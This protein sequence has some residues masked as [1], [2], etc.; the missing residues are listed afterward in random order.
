MKKIINMSLIMAL[1][2]IITISI[3]ACGDDDDTKDMTPP[4]ISAEG[5]TANPINC[6]EYHPGDVIPFHYVMTDNQELGAY[7]IEIHNNFDHH[8]HSTEADDHDH[9]HGT[10][11]CEED[12]DHEHE[13][14]EGKA[15]VYNQD[16]TIPAG[17]RSYDA[18]QD[19]QIPAD[20][21]PGD[22]HFMVRLT[23]RAGWQQLHAV[24]IKIVE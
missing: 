7:N 14:H 21:A 22:Y 9:D 2:S 20:A 3:A 5:I 23:D 13:H 16:F 19:I 8:S 4:T 12:H 11:E 15:W 18:R 17:L 1:I 10:G 24:A 6:Q